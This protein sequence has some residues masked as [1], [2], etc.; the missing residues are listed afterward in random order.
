MGCNALYTTT[1]NGVTLIWMNSKLL[2]FNLYASSLMPGGGPYFHTSPVSPSDSMNLVAAFNSGFKMGDSHGG[3]YIDGRAV[4]PLI[5]GQ[6]SAVISSDG[7]LNVGSWGTEIPMTPTVVAVRQNLTLL[8]DNGAVNPATSSAPYESWGVTWPGGPTTKRS[9][10]GVTA[11][12][13][14]LF[15]AGSTLTVAQLAQAMAAGGAVRAMSL[16]QNSYYPQFSA[17]SPFGFTPA[18]PANANN[19]V[20]GLEASDRYFQSSW[21]RDFFTASAL[22]SATGA[23]TGNGASAALHVHPRVH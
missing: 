22:G 20:P 9:A 7:S 11:N 16:D 18:S 23:A 2:S 17:F 4:S 14:V 3:Y 19:V 8:V 12:G 10:V 13:A 21:N 5:N 15:G 6:A 1:L